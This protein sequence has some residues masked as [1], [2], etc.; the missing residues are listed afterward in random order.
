MPDH[1]ASPQ[2]AD[3]QTTKKRELRTFL[4]TC[5]ILFPGLAVGFV[6]AYGFAVWILQMIFG[7]PGPPGA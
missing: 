4:F 1:D 2:G 5:F 3:A 6:G 7:P